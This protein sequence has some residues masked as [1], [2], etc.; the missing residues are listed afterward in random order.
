LA[1]IVALDHPRT[2]RR[3]IWL[4]GR[5]AATAAAALVLTGTIGLGWVFRRPWFEGN[6]AVVDP[7][8]VIRSAQPTTELP[9]LIE[10]F[11]LRSILNLR[12]G[13]GS[14]WWYDAE[15]K[16][17]E[18]HGV[19]FYDL[20]LAATRRPTRREL[21]FLTDL[22][23]NCPYPILIHC[24]SGADRTGLASALYLMVKRN[25]PPEQAE[26]A[27]ALEFG[28]VPVLGT[29]HLHEPLREYAAW[30]KDRGLDHSPDRFRAWVRTE[31]HSAD[32]RV[33]PLHWPAGPRAAFA[34][35]RSNQV[36]AARVL[37]KAS[38]ASEPA[39]TGPARPSSVP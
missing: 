26:N 31:Y 19:T 32:P 1:W 24:K 30:L 21:L 34:K 38:T 29:E 36:G 25:E 11:H 22:L 18:V 39:E 5:R 28:H 23:E 14:D 7:G 12:G 10:V 8:R 16:A 2:I 35:S 4:A 33:D 9:R 20:P 3:S 13:S 27:L 6:L 37:N 17:A 15:V